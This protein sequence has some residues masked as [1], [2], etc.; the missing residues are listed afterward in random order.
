MPDNKYKFQ[1]GTSMAS[2][3][4]AGTAALI[5]V[6]YP[7]LSGNQ[8]RQIIMENTSKYPNQQVIVP[9]EGNPNESEQ[10]LFQ[11]LSVSDGVVNVYKA[12]LAAEKMSMQ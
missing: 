4:V 1:E 12:L 7:E 9:H 10:R 5:M 8:V 3:V 6:Y 11:A 2:P